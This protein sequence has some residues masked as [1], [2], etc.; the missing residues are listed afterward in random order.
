VKILKTVLAQ[1]IDLIFGLVTLGMLVYYFI[2]PTQNFTL[3]L[4]VV[5]GYVSFNI[6]NKVRSYNYGRR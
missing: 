4:G 5:V 3:F 2:D 1:G 6:I